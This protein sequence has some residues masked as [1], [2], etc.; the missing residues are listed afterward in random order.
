MKKKLILSVAILSTAFL[1]TSCKKENADEIKNVTLD[2]SINA[3]EAYKLDLSQYGDADDFATI[4]KQA[5][6]FTTSEIAKVGVIGE[7]NFM[8][9]GSPKVGGN[10]NETVV[11]KVEEG[12][13]DGRCSGDS[14]RV[15]TN[16]SGGHHGKKHHIDETNITIN[17]TI[18]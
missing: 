3:G 6:S 18:L 4:T 11:L 1:F 17:F 10:G 13:G 2:V 15:H 9:A 5:A 8:K 14:T 16:N 7:Y 12:K